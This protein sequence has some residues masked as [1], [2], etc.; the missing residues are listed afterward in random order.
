[1]EVDKA[2]GQGVILLTLVFMVSAIIMYLPWELT[3]LFLAFV[4]GAIVNNV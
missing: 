2:I 1:M 4:A 3:A